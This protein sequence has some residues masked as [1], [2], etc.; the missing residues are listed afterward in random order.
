MGLLSRRRADG[1]LPK[2]DDKKKKKK[3]RRLDSPRE[4]AAC[5]AGRLIRKR[6]MAERT[7]RIS[8]MAPDI[9]AWRRRVI[10]DA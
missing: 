8:M 2:D 1:G 6:I 9:N 7:I 4:N 10:F 5:T 3:Q